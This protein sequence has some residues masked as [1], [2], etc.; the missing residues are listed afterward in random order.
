MGS[1]SG[2]E[3]WEGSVPASRTHRAALI[4]LTRTGRLREIESC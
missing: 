3:A 2:E 1:Y 4:P